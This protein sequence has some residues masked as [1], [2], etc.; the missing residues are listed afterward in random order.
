MLKMI[1][2]QEAAV[3]LRIKVSQSILANENGSL[4]PKLRTELK[5]YV[6]QSIP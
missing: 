3:A 5:G 4:N 2:I 1:A 6:S